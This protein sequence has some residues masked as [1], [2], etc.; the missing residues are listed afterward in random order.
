MHFLPHVASTWTALQVTNV[1]YILY[2]T[3]LL[4]GMKLSQLAILIEN[5]N[6]L[7]KVFGDV[8]TRQRSR[9]V[10]KLVGL[11]TTVL[12]LLLLVGGVWW[13]GGG[14]GEYI[15]AHGCLAEDIRLMMLCD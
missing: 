8:S 6:L 7:K 3:M 4:P 1:I 10:E 11:L 15:G 14:K 13:V 5:H 2:M 12:C 9:G